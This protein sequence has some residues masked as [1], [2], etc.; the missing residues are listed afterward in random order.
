MCSLH[1]GEFL[2]VGTIFPP[3]PLVLLVWHQPDQFMRERRDRRNR[4][5]QR[6]LPARYH[7]AVTFQHGL[8][9][10]LCHITGIILLGRAH[11]SIHHAGA[12]EELRLRCSWH[13]TGDKM[14]ATTVSTASGSMR[15][16]SIVR[17]LGSRSAGPH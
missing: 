13:L 14:V 12:F 1:G 5:A 17:K 2:W 11:L 10:D 4:C 9:A 8:K 15:M 7:V 16:S 3:R 6:I